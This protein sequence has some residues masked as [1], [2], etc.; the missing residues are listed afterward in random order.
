MPPG[1]GIGIGSLRQP[2]FGGLHSSGL[3]PFGMGIG[4]TGITGG[5]GGI[6]T[7][8]GSSTSSS[9]STTGPPGMIGAGVPHGAGTGGN[10]NTLLDTFFTYFGQHFPWLRRRKVE[11]RIRA[12]TMSAFLLNAM[13]AL[14]VR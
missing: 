12:G 13:N 9:G 14:A 10:N 4:I 5:G 11:E 1:I 6:G 7:M 8:G 3:G 2:N